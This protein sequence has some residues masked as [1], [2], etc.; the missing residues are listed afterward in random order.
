MTYRDTFLAILAALIWGAT[1][2][3]SAIA[4]EDTPPIFFTFLRFL[5][6][7]AFIVLVPRPKIG[8]K[9]LVLLGLLMGAGQYG[10]MFVAMS[11]GMPAGM[12]AVLVHTQAIFTVLIAIV[13]LNERPTTRTHLTL[14]L[15]SAGL[16]CLLFDRAQGG[17]LVGFV[18]MIFA[19]LCGATGNIILKTAGKVEMI[20]VAVWMSV[21]PLIPL[22]FLSGYLEGGSSIVELFRTVSWTT[23]A[24]I[25]YSA[26][27]A[28][29]VVYTI[30][31]RLLVTY[32]TGQIA[33]FF[34]LVPMFGLGLSA[35][36]LGEEFSTLQ[37]SGSALIFVGLI[38]SIFPTKRL[39]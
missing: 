20:S 24:A 23:L 21:A 4:L 32:S 36:I 30:W 14:I 27:L 33:P 37:L 8:W 16:A 38:V 29:V 22:A 18:L 9:K 7:A 17:A 25:G 35:L 31:G 11:Q 26:I 28:T 19:A 12:A 5:C 39:V 1:F 15:A 34:L 2:P 13:F 10:F 6:A 3:I